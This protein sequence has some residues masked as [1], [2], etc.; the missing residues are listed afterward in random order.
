V[1]QVSEVLDLTRSNVADKL[2]WPIGWRDWRFA[3]EAYDAGLVEEI[4]Q[5]IAHLPS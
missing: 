5:A 1:K 4:R 2:A 3:C